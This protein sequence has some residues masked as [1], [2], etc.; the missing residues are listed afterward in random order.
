MIGYCVLQNL[1]R[2]FYGKKGKWKERLE[3]YEVILGGAECVYCRDT[4][5]LGV[6][7]LIVVT[8]PWVSANVQIIIKLRHI[9]NYGYFLDI[10]LYI[11]KL[12]NIGFRRKVS[13][14]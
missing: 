7:T 5:P 10:L 8:I 4:I 11:S 9:N 1:L 13:W 12:L 14:K 2:D 6:N 3:E